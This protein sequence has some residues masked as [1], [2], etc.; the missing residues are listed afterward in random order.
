MNK[1]D[2]SHNTCEADEEPETVK[3][4]KSMK[5]VPAHTSETIKKDTSIKANPS[6]EK[7]LKVFFLNY[8]SLLIGFVVKIHNAING[9][10]YLQILI[11][12]IFLNH[13]IVL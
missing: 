6:Q 11:L 8:F 13:F 3:S 2:K 10:N 9:V 5:Y 7:Y 12:M 1:W 4:Y